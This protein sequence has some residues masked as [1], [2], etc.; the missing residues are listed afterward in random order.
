MTKY[1]QDQPFTVGLSSAKYSTGWDAI[2]AK[3]PTCARH[4]SEQGD[5]PFM[6]CNPPS[7]FPRCNDSFHDETK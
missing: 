2:F 3:C 5:P 7:P 6:L 1:L 4:K